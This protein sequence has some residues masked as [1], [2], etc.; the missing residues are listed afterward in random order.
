MIFY[1]S[2]R[3]LDII[4]S[5]TSAWTMAECMQEHVLTKTRL[6]IQSPKFLSMFV[7]EIIPMDCQRW[8]FFHVYVVDSWKRIPIL[9]TLE[10]VLSSA[11]VDNLTNVI[12]E[13]LLY[14]MEA[15]LKLSWLPN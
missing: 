11:I 3:A 14:S 1:K 12:M 9:L 5:D 10:Q 2:Q 4:E 6:I 15:F 7:D 13:N 8:I